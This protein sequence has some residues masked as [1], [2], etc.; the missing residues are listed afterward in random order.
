[1]ELLDQRDQE[2]RERK[3]EAVADGEGDPYDEDDRGRA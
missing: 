2:Y 3:V 1:V